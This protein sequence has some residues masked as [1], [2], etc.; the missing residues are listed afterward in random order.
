MSTAEITV[1]HL[2]RARSLRVL[3]LLEEL[4][5]PYRVDVLDFVPGKFGGESYT[6]IHPL[7]KVPAIKDG[8][9]I[10]YES[11]AIM[12]YI[13]DRYAPGQLR[14]DVRDPDY[15][16]YLQFLHYGESTLAPVIASLMYQRHFFPPEQR[17]PQIEA[18]AEVE[19]AKVLTLLEDQLA[20]HD[21]I[22]KSGFSA[23]D[24]SVGYC[25][26]LARIARAHA[27]LTDRIQEYWETLTDRDAWHRISAIK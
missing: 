24:I 6:K 8:E 13:M 18:W 14:P 9:T 10:M 3:W 26:L 2:P 19:L 21:Y 4:G 16:T 23:A 5:L 15:G 1:Y 12:Q 11:V 17:C 20:D 7:N 25:L 27:Q 22:L